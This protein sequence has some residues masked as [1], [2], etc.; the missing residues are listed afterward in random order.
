M[1]RKKTFSTIFYAL[2]TLITAVYLFMP[3]DVISHSKPVWNCEY[4]ND[5]WECTVSCQVTNH[6]DYKEKRKVSIRGFR[7]ISTSYSSSASIVGEKTVKIE[8]KPYEVYDFQEVIFPRKKPDR[9]NINIW[10]ESSTK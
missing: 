7:I 2:L 3:G 10:E 8:V 4:R 9:I 6:S 1:N 5:H